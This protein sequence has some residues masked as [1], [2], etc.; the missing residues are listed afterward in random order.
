[1]DAARTAKRLGGIVTIVYRRTQAEMPA[2]VEELHHA[3]EEGIELK[4]LRSPREFT[5]EKSTH[6]CHAVLDVM[7]LGLP[8]ASGRRAPV[9]TGKTETMPVDLVIMALGNASNPIIK[10]SEPDLKTTKWGTITVGRGSQKTS[11][12]GV[13]SGGDATRGGATAVLAAGDGQAAARE[14]VGDIPFSK[15]EIEELVEHAGRYTDVAQAPQTILKKVDLAGGIV[16][17]TVKSPLI[18]KAAQAGQFVRLLPT[19]KGELIPLTLA[20]WDADAG[21]I[22]LVIQAVGASTIGINAMEVGEAF[23][24]IA[25]PLGQPSRVHRY[26]ADQTVVFCAGG[27]G[28]PPVFPIM[29]AHLKLGNHVTLI[30]GFR[31]AEPPLLDGQGRARRPAA[32]GVSGTARRDLRQQR[33]HLRRQGLRHRPARTAVGS[34]QA[35]QGRGI[36]EVVAIGPPLMMRAVS[37]LTKPY[38]V[39][40]VASLNSIMVDATG[41]CGACMVPVTIDGKLVRKHACIDGPEIDAHIIDWD[42][43][44]PRFG[45]FKPQE[46]ESRV[47]AAWPCLD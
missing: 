2:R 3:L 30:A 42:K 47:R 13:Y 26:E 9:V 7:E 16:E 46:Q 45:Q 39:P 10:D 14:I 6:V 32:T 23:S 12:E 8:D 4:V 17:M 1:M 41:M 37:E 38:G 18:A 43:F 5:S 29:R 31:S 21:T 44:L 40:T 35:G 22:D 20:D 19:P 15:A 28:L 36:A 34:E 33:R 24:G 27:L 11:L 25:G